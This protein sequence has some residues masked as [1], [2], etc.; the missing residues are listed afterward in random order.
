MTAAIRTRQLT[1]RYGELRAVDA[2]DLEVPEGAVYGF[3][4]ANGSGKTTTVRML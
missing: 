4:G 3:L 1:K 2:I